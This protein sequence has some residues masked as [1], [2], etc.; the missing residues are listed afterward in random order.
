MD[1][2]D[3]SLLHKQYNQLFK[4]REL[5][6]HQ[7]AVKIIFKEQYRNWSNDRTL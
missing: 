2:V 7:K 5:R 1:L 4:E 6:L 3:E